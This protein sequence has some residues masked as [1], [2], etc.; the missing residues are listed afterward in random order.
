MQITV[1]AFSDLTAEQLAAWRRYLAAHRLPNPLNDPDYL[2]SLAAVG[3]KISIILKE[4]PT[5]PVL[6][7]P[8][9]Y[10]GKRAIEPAAKEVSDCS[11]LIVAPRE[12]IDPQAV[13]RQAGLDTFH[14]HHLFETT[15][16]DVPTFCYFS[17]PCYLIDLRQGWDAYARDLAARGSKLLTEGRRKFRKLQREVGPVRLELA[18]PPE[19]LDLLLQWKI[20]QLDRQ[21]FQHRFDEN[22]VATFMDHHLRQASDHVRGH[23]SALYAGNEPVALHYGTWGYGVVNSW[24]PAVNPHFRRY[25][26]ALLLYLELAR[27]GE[28]AGFSTMILGRGGNQTKLRLA[29]ATVA[30]YVGAI[31]TNAATRLQ[32]CGKKGLYRLSRSNWGRRFRKLARRIRSRRFR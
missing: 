23:L 3:R 1:K 11:Q 17:D 7:W 4:D 19:H 14:F 15:A 13:L 8:F 18:S 31:P 5:G 30:N 20:A 16:F 32:F 9:E 21:G 28:R 12:R 2:A 29:N 27:H 6:F 25:S 22:W 26:P 10:R 24:V